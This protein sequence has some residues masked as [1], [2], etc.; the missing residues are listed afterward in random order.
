[1]GK[2]ALADLL[3]LEKMVQLGDATSVAATCHVG[4][5]DIYMKSSSFPAKQQ[6]L[7]HTMPAT[8]CTRLLKV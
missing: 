7:Q 1:M 8:C 5:A 6:H 3:S 4:M 2:E